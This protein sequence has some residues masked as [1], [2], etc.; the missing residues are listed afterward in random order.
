MNNSL[1]FETSLDPYRALVQ[2]VDTFGRQV[3]RLFADR[4]ACRKGCAGCCLLESV[5]PVEAASLDLALKS[6]PQESFQGLVNT[7]NSVSTNC[8]LL[9][10]GECSIYAA[11]PLICRTHGLPLLI[12]EEK[13]NRVDVCDKNFVGGGSLP[14]EAVL[15]LEALNAALVM[16]NRRFLQEHPGFAADGERVLLADLI[17]VRS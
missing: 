16:I 1:S 12:R 4:M 5:L 11:R 13:G 7:A 9:L 3:H 17:S 8:P 2:K 14:G 10:N 6:L 15:D